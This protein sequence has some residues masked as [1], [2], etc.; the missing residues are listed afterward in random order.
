MNQVSC[1]LR[2]CLGGWRYACL[3]MLATGLLA[4]SSTNAIAEL[5]TYQALYNVSLAG[6]GSKASVTWSKGALA[7]RLTRDCRK[8]QS[9][10]EFFF[11][12]EFGDGTRFKQHTMS[13]VRESL[14]GLAMEYSGWRDISGTARADFSGSARLA[15]IGGVGAITVVQPRKRLLQI[16]EGAVFPISA[17]RTAVAKLSAG[18]TT[19]SVSYFEEGGEFAKILLVP[20]QPIILQA[21]PRGDAALVQGRSWKLRIDQIFEDEEKNTGAPKKPDAPFTILQVH[22]T[23]VAS[24]LFINLG[25]GRSVTATLVE[26]RAIPEP[27]C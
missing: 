7:I 21:Q 5:S 24:Y 20:S 19:A 27:K 11:A 16:P 10:T 2:R 13:R 23:G 18:E 4:V 12:G 15:S 6:V 17:M 22:E 25:D 26:V 9:Q 14:N 3:T 1:G 8:W